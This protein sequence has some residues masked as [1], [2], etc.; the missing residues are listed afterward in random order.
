MG[1]Q[2]GTRTATPRVAVADQL[3][4]YRR[5][6]LAAL[7]EAGLAGE[8]PADVVAWAARA[9]A[10]DPGAPAASRPVAVLLTIGCPQQEAMLVRLCAQAPEAV[11][12][13]LLPD[14]TPAAYRQ[15]LSAGATAAIDY[16][17]PL[18]RIIGVLHAAIAGDACLPAP[19]VQAIAA[20]RGG[21]QAAGGSCVSPTEVGWLR[22]LAQG[23]HVVELA[24]LAGYSERAMYRLLSQLF[25]RMA[26]ANRHEAILRADR[27]GLLDKPETPAGDRPS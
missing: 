17:A 19:V 26:V 21:G 3:P 24:R 9:V 4:A 7:A 13:G 20:G 1:G 11:V 15:A 6:L 12:V 25:Q 16:H 22:L 27:W 23:T 10:L 8:E 5:G 14:P 18:E 2:L